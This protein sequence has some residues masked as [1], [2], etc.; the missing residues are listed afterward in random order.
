[1]K[2]P[3]NIKY[4]PQIESG[5]YKVQTRDG[6]PARI[7]CWDRHA[8][9]PNDDCILVALITLENNSESALYYYS[10]GH[11]WN[12]ANGEGD[13]SSDLFII[14]PEAELTDLEKAIKRG[15]LCAGLEGVSTTIIKETAK[16]VKDIICKECTVGLEQYWKGYEGAKERFEKLKTFYCPTY[17]PPCYHGGICTNPMR[18]CINCPRTGGDIGISTTSGTCKKD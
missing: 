7:I 5:K 12:K 14:T 8:T 9:E 16:E 15:M 11:L 4:R 2:I 1:M 6:S 18:D 13:S 10:D 17:E 3:F